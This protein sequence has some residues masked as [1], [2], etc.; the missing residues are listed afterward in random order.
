MKVLIIG[1]SGMIGKKLTQRLL[2]MKSSLH[3]IS[4]LILYDIIDTTKPKTDIPIKILSGDIS[5]LE[6]AKILA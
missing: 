2:D 6:Q 5:K 3:Q 4:E 1:A